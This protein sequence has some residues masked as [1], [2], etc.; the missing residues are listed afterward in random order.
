MRNSKHIL[1][2]SYRYYDEDPRFQRE[3]NAL[4]RRGYQVDIVCPRRSK[5]ENHDVAPLSRF[6]SPVIKRRRGSI[7]RYLF[8]YIYFF[9]FALLKVTS[10][11]IKHHYKIIQVFVMPEALLLTCII[12]KLLGAKILM[13]WEDPSREIF[14]TKFNRWFN[15]PFLW[16]ISLVE[17]ISVLLAD[18]IIVPN[19]GFRRAFGQR[20]LP[21]EKIKIVMNGP[22]ATLFGKTP[23][24][25]SI[26]LS[27]YAHPNHFI[28]LYNGTIIHRHGLHVALQALQKVVKKIPNV[29]LNIIGDGDV[30][31]MNHCIDMA[32]KYGLKNN[33][34]FNGRVTI[35]DIPDFVRNASLGII[36]NLDTPFTR[37]NFPQRI[38]EFGF[39]RKPVIVARLPG[40]E[41]YVAEN[42]VCF[43]APGNHDELAEKIITFYQSPET[44]KRLGEH[45]FLTCT[46]MEWEQSYAHIVERMNGSN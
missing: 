5:T 7:G 6:Y 45:A 38:M 46:K 9:L 28:I 35:S 32:S 15:M 14:L 22:D 8:E 43:F 37:I 17:R 44:M 12:A 30:D 21:A 11:Q 18:E 42:D 36:P 1:M 26:P 4:L 13:D 27:S 25:S 16:L 23:S 40:I 3:A 34:R 2:L 20:G 19:E 41:D 31:Y 24:P 33:T 29:Y 39:L 10:L